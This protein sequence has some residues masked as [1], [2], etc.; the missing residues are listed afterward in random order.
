MIKRVVKKSALV[1]GRKS[2]Q[3]LVKTKKKS[4]LVRNVAKKRL[5]RKVRIDYSKYVK[6]GGF[7]NVLTDNVLTKNT[8]D[9]SKYNVIK[10]G[11]NKIEKF[12]KKVIQVLK[13]QI[14]YTYKHRY[15]RRYRR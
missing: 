7:S 12:I 6:Q 15:N 5:E 1:K 9:D 13:F 10:N 2:K 3:G 11:L 4:V 14:N 8:K